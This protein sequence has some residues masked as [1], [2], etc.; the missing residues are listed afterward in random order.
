MALLR[1][2]PVPVTDR[3]RRQLE[4][5]ERQPTCPQQLAVRARI[6]L[7]AS[8]DVGVR[9]TADEL[10]I[11]RSTVQAWRRRW[12]ENSDASVAERLS[13]APRPGTPP[14]FTA[15]QIC[16]I[17]ALACEDPRESGRAITHWTQ[18]EVADEAMK[19]GIVPSIS[20]RS[21]GRFFKIS[22]PQTTS[23][24]RL[25]ERQTRPPVRGETPRHLRDVPSGPGAGG[26]GN[27]DDIY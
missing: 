20:S 5:L 24:S 15:E 4:A 7:L 2:A 14:I 16:A 11:G 17:V 13:D 21:I 9:A 27:Q 1:A 22:G 8:R 3:E 26:S 23:Q 6:I 10:G 12:T 19:R 18:W 25:A